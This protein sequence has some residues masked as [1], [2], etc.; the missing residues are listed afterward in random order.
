MIIHKKYILNGDYDINIDIDNIDDIRWDFDRK[1]TIINYV[2]DGGLKTVKIDL[3]LKEVC[4]MIA[5]DMLD[6]TD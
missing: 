4:F 6:L 1:A 3:K 5:D 2:K